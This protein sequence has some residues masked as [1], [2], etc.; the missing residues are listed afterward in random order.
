MSQSSQSFVN[1]YTFV[2]GGGEETR[3]Q[4][5]T[6]HD[7]RAADSYSGVITVSWRLASPLL[8]PATAP[9][10]GWFADD[11]GLQMP[12]SS[13]AGAVRSLH[14]A[15]FNGCF[16][17]V[18]LDYVPSYRESAK[19]DDLQLAVV[20]KASSDGVPTELRRCDETVWVDSG[21][22]LRRWPQQGRLPT[23]GDVVDL[24]GTV[25]HTSLGRAEFELLNRVE[26]VHGADA[27]PAPGDDVVGKRVLLVT[28][29]SARKQTRRD[30]THARALWATGRLT[31][32]LIGIDRTKDA[33]MLERWKAACAGSED[34]RVLEQPGPQIDW[35]S[36]TTYDPVTWW[37]PRGQRGFRVARRARATGQLF[38]GDVVWVAL[39]D[40]PEREVRVAEMKLAQIWR[41]AGSKKVGERLPAHQHPCRPGDDPQLCLT[42]ATFGAADTEGGRDQQTSYAG[43]VRFGA[44]RTDTSI[45]GL[46]SPIDLAPLG[47]PRPG[48]GAFYL[49]WDARPLPERTN[50]DVATHWGSEAE[51]AE[52]PLAGRKFYWHS[53]PDEQ[54]AALT[55]DLGRKVGPRHLP[56]PQQRRGRMARE[57]KIV[58]AGTV[59]TSTVSFDQLDAVAVHALLAALSPGRVLART[60]GKPGRVF[61]THLGGGK[62]FGFGSAIPTLTRVEIA[63]TRDRY[64]A[65][66][67][68]NTDWLQA[69]F[70]FGLVS[71]RVGRFTNKLP[72]LARV[73]DLDGLGDLA[74]LVAYPPGSSWDDYQHP[75]PKRA[76][77]FGQ[78]YDWFKNATGLQLAGRSSPW[79]PLPAPTDN[80]A[81]PTDPNRRR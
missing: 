64:A 65:P 72:A 66:S 22:L 9:E 2:R 36:Q 70:P 39:A 48:Y 74:H 17:V 3:R 78:S 25:V 55:R 56:T 23:S 52:R 63:R 10:E 53:G 38:A 19:T 29:T 50:G 41:E 58:K 7:G 51:N 34:R 13:V 57:A 76:D 46:V 12:G 24:R 28:S 44:A 16:R 77:A 69:D 15:L 49:A 21:D 18:D 30:R 81:L 8:L 75:D 43:H 31:T 68:P 11:G 59:L 37:G 26:V 5:P 79:L 42:C 33:A 80:P 35:R 14:E 47:Q 62:P 6:F 27:H 4:S 45:N 73:L 54:A 1:P 40:D 60:P 61:A 71:E 32:S 20:T 67:G